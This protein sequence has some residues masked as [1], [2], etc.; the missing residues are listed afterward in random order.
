MIKA[1]LKEEID[2]K[3]LTLLGPYDPF[4][5][6][7]ENSAS[8]RFWALSEARYMPN[9]FLVLLKLKEEIDFEISP[10]LG[11]LGPFGAPNPEKFG[12]TV[13]PLSL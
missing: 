6:L 5:A 7:N 4:G 12:S 13:C 3:I 8:N 2:F 9:I 11:L 10:L 1:K